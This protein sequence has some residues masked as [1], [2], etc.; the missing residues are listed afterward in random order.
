MSNMSNKA[1]IKINTSI[2]PQA[3]GKVAVLMGGISGEREISLLSGQ[4]VLEALLEKGV[5][6]Y[7][8][9]V[10][11]DI[12]ER[13]IKDKPDRV[14]LALHGTQGED[15]VIQ[16][17]LEVLQIPYTGSG[18][19]ASALAMDKYQAKIIWRHY[20]LPVLPSVLVSNYDELKQLSPNKIGFD[21]PWCIKPNENGSTLGISKVSN[22]DELAAAFEEAKK[23]SSQVMIEPWIEI[24]REFT[25]PIFEDQ[26]LPPIEIVAEKKFYDYKAKY[27]SDDTKFFCPCKLTPNELEQLQTLALASFKT[28][29]C[30]HFARADF[31]QDSQGKFWLLEINTIPGLTTHSLVPMAVKA[32]GINFADFIWHVLSLTLPPN[33][34]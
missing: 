34:T 16:G 28:L 11:T 33:V 19:K 20:N 23:Y 15:G 22:S 13:L 7:G 4:H 27:L 24:L 21:F 32:I 17:L 5:N 30:R 26:A 6:A 14:F 10:G 29:D 9:D 18:V 2:L 3:F 12:A 31:I 8:I 1:N 25:V